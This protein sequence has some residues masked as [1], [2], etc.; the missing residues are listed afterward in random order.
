A[1]RSVLCA[2]LVMSEEAFALLYLENRDIS[3]R[4]Q[5]RQREV[6]DEFCR[7]AAPRLR[8][9]LAVE[10][11]RQQA[12]ALES[13]LGETDG[14]LTADGGMAG[15]LSTVRQVAITE[16]PVLIQG[17]TGTGKELVARALWRRSR[18]ANAPFLVLNCAA[19]PATLVESELFGNV[20]GAFTGATSDR[21]GMIGAAD[22]GTLLLDEIGEMPPEVQPRLLRVLQSGEY[23]RLGSS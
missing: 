18:R 15:V 2:P 5:E 10:H 1:V 22:R 21:T 14:I 23:T 20:R 9:A 19:I 13:G 12:R 16:L 11:A 8:N 7:L 17:E 3:N 6:L 4:F